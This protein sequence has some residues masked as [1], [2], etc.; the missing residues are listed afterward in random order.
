MMGRIFLD[1][2]AFTRVAL[3]DDPWSLQEDILH[4][5]ANRPRTAVKACHASGKSRAAADATLWYLTRYEDSI[6][7]LTAPTWTQVERILWGEIHG[8]IRRSRIAYPTP[9]QTDLTLGEGNYAIGISTNDSLRFQ[10]FHAAHMLI[11]LDEAPGVL[12]QIYEAIEG[13]RAGGDVR[14]LYL[15][16]PTVPSGPFYE[17]FTTNRELWSLFTI[18]GLDTPNLRT[19]PGRTPAERLE[20]LVC[21]S[22]AEERQE[23][24][25][26]YLTTREWIYERFF[27]WGGK[28]DEENGKRLVIEPRHPMWMPR[29]R[30]QFPPFDPYAIV[31]LAECEAA[32][33]RPVIDRGGP[34]DAG[35]DVAG[36][37]EDETVLTLCSGSTILAQRCWPEPDPRGQVVAA[38]Q[39]WRARLREIRVDSVGIGYYMAKHLEDLGFSVRMVNVGSQRCDRDRFKNQ[40]AEFYETVRLRFQSGEVTGLTDEVTIAQLLSV[41]ML[42]NSRG[43]LEVESKDALRSRGVKSPDRAESLMLAWARPQLGWSLVDVEEDAAPRASVYDRQIERLIPQAYEQPSGEETC[44]TCMHREGNRCALRGFQVRV[45]DPG[46]P[47][48]E[49]NQNGA[50][51]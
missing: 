10:G 46:C 4:S 13:I 26:P 35:L 18:D 17:A 45:K 29:A 2:V 14:L 31:S 21:D 39:P 5:V 44:G 38:L 15:G 12:A 8:A 37:G 32:K 6:V 40:K 3:Q 20:Y 9:N 36:P 23:N 1:P 51:T 11:I 27:E 41:R 28:V 25:R 47:Q 16:N 43:Q 24:V 48:W 34:V 7:V 42:Q 30:G 49:M 33:L 22:T 19:L 50:G